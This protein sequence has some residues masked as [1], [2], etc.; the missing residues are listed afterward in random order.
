MKIIILLI[1]LT[2]FSYFA[3]S[4]VPKIEKIKKKLDGVWFQDFVLMF[5]NNLKFEDTLKGG[6]FQEEAYLGFT[7]EGNSVEENSIS[8]ENLEVRTTGFSSGPWGIELIKNKTIIRLD[9][10]GV[11]TCGTYEIISFKRNEMIL[12]SF[13]KDVACGYYD[14]Y[15][16][17]IKK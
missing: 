5:D 9:C 14:Y 10:E 6:L 2:S 8:K 1:A 17:R 11:L 12:R 16:K 15:F 3:V 13:C 7:I 4:R